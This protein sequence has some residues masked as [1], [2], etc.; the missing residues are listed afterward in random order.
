MSVQNMPTLE[1]RQLAATITQQN[2]ERVAKYDQMADEL[3]LQRDSFTE[4]VSQADRAW[5]QETLRVSE[6]FG[7]DN[8]TFRIAKTRYDSLLSSGIDPNQAT[9][10]IVKEFATYGITNGG[11]F[12]SASDQ[13]DRLWG[14]QKTAIAQ[15]LDMDAQQFQIGLKQADD[16]EQRTSAIWGSILDDR[17]VL[18]TD[19]DFSNGANTALLNASEGLINEIL[20]TT[21]TAEGFDSF[22]QMADNPEAL[23][24]NLDINSPASVAI[25][26]ILKQSYGDVTDAQLKNYIVSYI[27]G[28]KS[29]GSTAVADARRELQAIEAGGGGYSGYD[30]ADRDRNDRIRELNDV[31]HA[32]I[33]EHG[34]ITLEHVDPA[35]VLQMD[36]EKMQ[37][38]FALLNG[39]NV[40]PERAAAGGGSFL[41]SLMGAV[42]NVAG[43]YVG[44]KVK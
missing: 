13:F 4:G 25:R 33:G 42:G 32:Q 11:D 16:Q 37:A 23:A 3:G 43:A 40:T 19:I 17:N 14:A 41:D 20:A 15:Q 35:W 44:A 38:L 7:I 2:M 18:T 31:I 28:D 8:N 21:P 29:A 1:S 26:D 12:L 34:G 10:Q 9:V 22:F 27:S 5:N 30:D 36:G 24:S 6:Q 39:G